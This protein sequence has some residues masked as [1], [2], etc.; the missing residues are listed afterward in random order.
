MFSIYGTWLL[1]DQIHWNLIDLGRDFSPVINGEWGQARFISIKEKIDY[2]L[3]YE[4]EGNTK[5]N[6]QRLSPLS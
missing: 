2:N 5:T 4:K 1:P 3:P 6:H